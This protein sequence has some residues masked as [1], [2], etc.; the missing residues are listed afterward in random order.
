MELSQRKRRVDVVL[1]G[2]KRKRILKTN[3]GTVAQKKLNIKLNIIKF[4]S[5]PHCKG[6][7]LPRIHAGRTTMFVRENADLVF[8]PPE[9]PSGLYNTLLL[10]LKESISMYI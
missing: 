3:K 6:K 1:T 10:I 4:K 8:R 9:P 7:T 2:I 5:K